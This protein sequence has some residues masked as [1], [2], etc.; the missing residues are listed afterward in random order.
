MAKCKICKTNIPDGKELCDSC[1]DKNQKRRNESYLDGL[2]NS[3]INPTMTA[4]NQDQDQMNEDSV[5]Q[6]EVDDFNDY[7][8]NDWDDLDQIGIDDDLDRISLDNDLDDEIMI[9]DK[10]LF[11][12]E[13][14]NL[15][16]NEEEEA[17][18]ISDSQTEDIPAH[19]TTKEALTTD[20]SED[21][22]KN[23]SEQLSENSIPNEPEQ[24]SDAVSQ[25]NVSLGEIDQ[26][27]NNSS[28]EAAYD[29]IMEAMNQEV[30]ELPIDAINTVKEDPIPIDLTANIS[31]EEAVEETL[32]NLADIT[33][34]LEEQEEEIMPDHDDIFQLLNQI[35]GDDPVSEDAQA[36]SKM[37][38]QKEDRDKNI[39]NMPSDVGEVF[40]DALKV[41]SSLDDPEL[42][43]LSILESLPDLP[44][45]KSLS[46]P[47]AYEDEYNKKNKKQRRRKGED[48]SQTPF[49]EEEQKGPG[50]FKRLFGNIHDEKSK[51]AAEKEAKALEKKAVKDAAKKKNVKGKKGEL[52]A[53]E[54]GGENR[55]LKEKAVKKAKKEK[56]QKKPK[57]VISAIDDV[58][59]DEGR[60]NRLGASIVFLFFGLAVMVLLI[61]TNVFSYSLSIKNATKYFDRQK[62][63][64]A[65][66]EVYGIDIKDEDIE[67]YDKIMT[68]MFVNKQLNSYNNYFAMKK[69]PEALDSLLKGLNRYDKYIELATILGIDTDLNY[70]RNQ[71][72]AELNKEFHLSEADAIDILDS[73][74][75]KEYSLNVYDV[76]LERMNN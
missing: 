45:K 44:G 11:G 74:T 5:S 12:E 35:S 65:Y 67:I 64:Q 32:P 71:L 29:D 70:V 22:I 34:E 48:D 55:P 14:D 2:L 13:L 40:S 41:V 72:L 7:D 49:K 3:V 57:E 56:K 30:S 25:E 16:Y 24:L 63:T 47:G 27:E 52:A 10:D 39:S 33:Q 28:F 18:D 66:N 60:I 75:Q 8:L 21:I 4:N 19:E 6:Y 51:K 68:V 15:F 73:K 31:K 58:E 61:G 1:V 54:D 38:N 26:F 69:Y 42:D 20:L 9:H 43:E 59:V 76:V 46:V 50:L 62:Y 53:A 36:I 23:E 37:L 17:E